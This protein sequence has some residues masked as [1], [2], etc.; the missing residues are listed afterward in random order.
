MSSLIHTLEML[1]SVVG[2]WR[3]WVRVLKSIALIAR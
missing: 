2:T 1:S 3:R